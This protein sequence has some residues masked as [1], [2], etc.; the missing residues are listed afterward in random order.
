M[1]GERGY[2]IRNWKGKE[3]ILTV[4]EE[5][6]RERIMLIKEYFGEGWRNLE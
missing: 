1:V 6:E 2:A 4:K 5:R 3:P